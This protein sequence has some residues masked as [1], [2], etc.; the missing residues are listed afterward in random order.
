[1]SDRPAP[2]PGAA[3]SHESPYRAAFEHAPEAIL[4]LQDAHLVLLNEAA[5]RISG[6]S[7]DELMG[8]PFGSFVHPDD[9]AA[10]AELYARRLAGD[11]AERIFV[12]RI[13]DREG[14][15]RWLEVH[16]MPTL[17][18]GRPA[19][20]AFLAEVTERELGRAESER[21]EKML[22]RISEVSPNFIFIYDYEL[23]RDVYINRS[24][25]A[26][27]GYSDEEEAALQPYPFAKLC[28]PADLERAMARDE[29]WEEIAEGAVDAV[30][31]RLRAA[32]GEWRWFRSLNTPF[33][34]D[35]VGR[36]VQ[37]L[38]VSEDVTDRKR[39]DEALRR[40][41][42][43]TSLA[44]LAG[45]LAHDFGNLL[46]PVLGRAELLLSRLEEDSPLRAHVTAIRT[47]AELAADLVEQLRIFSGQRPAETRA[48]DLNRIVA[49]VVEVLRPVT[50]RGV[51]VHFNLDPRLPWVSGDPSQLRQ[52][53]LNLL[54]NAF[55]ATGERGGRVD[56]RTRPSQLEAPDLADLDLA[57]G[58]APGP[59]IVLEVEDEGCGMDAATRARLW[60]PFFTTKPRGRGLGLPSVL[61]ILRRHGAGLEVDSRPGRGTRFAVFLPLAEGRE[62]PL[63]ANDHGHR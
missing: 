1:M 41:E 19:V 14:A 32:S 12:F 53:V 26:A 28:H 16:S 57:E 50:P 8:R 30:E 31:F 9:V 60:E 5:S 51:A 34:R 20:L 49:E 35:A 44:V 38:G 42:K 56:V 6:Y 63:A 37:I 45:G 11:T 24:V 39:A 36:I 61:G 18:A 52:V 4:V 59:A 15:V 17:W 58:V 33:R 55:E 46:T 13:L 48:V 40:S 7:R 54:T 27:L 62:L 25:P 23:G 2:E 29:R 43:L 47:S 21:R 22:E 10:V 3:A